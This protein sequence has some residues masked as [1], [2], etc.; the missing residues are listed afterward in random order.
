MPDSESFDAFY[1]R[2]VW[3]I[4]SE[5]RELAGNDG[6]A[7][8]AIREAYAK[9]YQQWY[10]VSGYSDPEGW[11][12]AT[13]KDAYERR[14]GE[15]GA[16]VGDAAAQAEDSGT[17]PGIYRP[18]P[19]AASRDAA[20]PYQARFDPDATLARPAAGARAAAYPTT[21]AMAGSP[22]R[23]APPRRAQRSAGARAGQLGSR[24]TQVIAGS[25]IAALVVAGIAYIASGG[26]P[27]APAASGTN[28]ASAGTSQTPQ[29]LPA[30]RTGQRSAVPWSLVGPGWA[31][32]EFSKAPP[33]SA[34]QA[35]GT[36]SYTTYLVDPEGGKYA[37][38]SS[39]AGTAP[40]L[41]AWS[42]DAHTALFDTSSGPAS[43][44]GSYQ[45][46]NAQTGAMTALPLPAGVVAV[47]FTR[48]HG[49]AILAVN[50]GPA[51]FH[52]QRYDLSGQLEKSLTSLPR[53]AGQV[54]PSDGC[55]GACAL[56]SPNGDV[57]VWGIAGDE[58]QAVGNAD[59][60]ARK[61]KVKVSGHAQSCVPLSWWD[62][63]TILASCADASL[64]G[65]ATGLWRVPVD[66][67]N[68]TALT[69]VAAAGNGHIDDAWLAGQTTYVT[70]ATS[71]Q[72]QSA[73]SGGLDIVP[74]GQGSSA[75][76]KIPGST[77]NVST[78]VTT[79]GERLLVLTQTSCPGTSSLLWFNPST[80][81]EQPAVTATSNEAGVIA[82]VPFGNGPT[83]VLNGQY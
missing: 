29:M 11:V 28:S 57:D 63:T 82:A 45:L 54:W 53:K 37:I 33:S 16:D 81:T 66:G 80:G 2:T 4:T 10:Q 15:A 24:R 65:D 1:G 46:L 41:M 30:G 47:G 56:S 43:G 51:K 39:P 34:G 42:G 72:C 8:H 17:W 59:G 31:L 75:A 61:L 50:V 68:P 67:S 3:S 79:Q 83:A 44:T 35:A 62:A 55:T 71:S 22:A 20:D 14:R 76:I 38:T 48:P 19:G 5:M 9:A 78:I 49:L 77:G 23:K 40:Q 32:A 27:N 70:S 26:H 69:A 74:L 36:G 58:M 25:A 7:D 73:P 21:D 60:K 52:L 64:P 6:L 12:L 13:A 18:R